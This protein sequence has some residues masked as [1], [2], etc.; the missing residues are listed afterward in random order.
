MSAFAIT[1]FHLFK[2]LQPLLAAK[3]TSIHKFRKLLH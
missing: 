1:I 2:H 3:T